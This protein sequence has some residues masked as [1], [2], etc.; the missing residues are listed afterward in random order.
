MKKLAA[1]TLLLIVTLAPCGFTL[2]APTITE[3]PQPAAAPSVDQLFDSLQSAAL[4]H[5]WEPVGRLVGLARTDG[6]AIATRFEE[7]L[8]ASKDAKVRLACA[9]AL[10]QVNRAEKAAAAL[11]DLVEHAESAEIRR[12]TASAITLSV[13]LHGNQTVLNAL[14]AAL[15][16]EKDDACRIVLA[17]SHMRITKANDGRDALKELLQKSTDPDIRDEAALVLA[18]NGGLSLPEV[19]ARVLALFT[20]PTERGERA[21]NLLKRAESAAKAPSNDPALAKGIDLIK[22]LTTTIRA[23]YADETKID[24]DKLFQNAAKGMVKGLDPFSQYLEPTEL[25]NLQESLHQEYA[26][27]GAYVGLRDNA[28]IIT[29]PIFKSPAYEAGLRALDVILEIDGQKVSALLD[30]GGLNAVIDKL[31]GKAGSEVKLKYRRRGFG[32]PVDITIVRQEIKVESVFA[33]MFPGDIAYIRLTKFGESSTK[34]M[35]DAVAEYVKK[36][37]A[38]GLVF[39]LRDNGGGLLKAGVDIAD[40]FLAG[41]KLVVYS[42]GRKEFSPR[43]DFFSTGGPEDEAVPMVTL[44]NGGTASASEIVSGALQ[45]H[46]RALLVGEKTFGKGSVQQILNVNATNNETRLRLTIAKYFLPSGRSIHEKG[47][48]PE[49]VQKQREPNGWVLETLA[50]LRRK[51]VFEDFVRKSWDAN[52]ELYMKLAQFDNRDC[53][54]WP[55]FDEF[56]AGLHTT[57][58]KDDIRVELRYVARHLAQEYRKSEFAADLEE[59]LILQRGV[60]EVLKKANIDPATHPEYKAFPETFKEP[61]KDT[62]KD[63]E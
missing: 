32:K 48:D 58:P 22:E 18:E 43:R 37:N 55:G 42:E 6:G 4:T 36:Q 44:V 56:Y 15:K 5:I 63:E 45:D 19:R 24:Y 54:A 11:A 39:D 47:I 26:G 57:A 60:Y 40:L 34:E 31:K 7:T 12:A 61:A 35:R 13:Q 21:L 30:K 1:L 8:G 14:A 46:K 28:F 62:K 50:D 49:I 25:K 10:C 52:K 9:R 23:A 17:R 41:K 38:K 3:K 59:D 51:N 53:S 29:S 33:T 16:A 20:E 2:E 27:I